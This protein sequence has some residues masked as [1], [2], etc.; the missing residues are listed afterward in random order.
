LMLDRLSQVC[1]KVLGRYG[2]LFIGGDG[3]H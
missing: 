2:E 1:Q 3:I